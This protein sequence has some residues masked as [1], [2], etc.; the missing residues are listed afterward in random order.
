MAQLPHLTDERL[1]Q[2]GVAIAA[3]RHSLLQAASALR[4]EGGGSSSSSSS[5]AA[6]GAAAG[7]AAPPPAVSRQESVDAEDLEAENV[8][9]I[10]CM[11]P[12]EA[13]LM[14]CG[15][16]GLCMS[17]AELCT[18][19]RPPVCPMCRARIVKVLQVGDPNEQG[20]VD[21]HVPEP[22]SSRPTPTSAGASQ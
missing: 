11:G 6:P 17:C 15:H 22:P 20:I 2:A 19:K 8:C 10:C 18:K 9:W 21:V 14:E 5:S 3:H 13:V 16:G 4:L 7:A 12:R 1:Q